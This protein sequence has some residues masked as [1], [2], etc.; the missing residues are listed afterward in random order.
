MS[1]SSGTNLWAKRL[2]AG[3][4]SSS[5]TCSARVRYLVRPCCG[6]TLGLAKGVGAEPEA[7]VGLPDRR[8]VLLLAASGWSKIEVGPLYAL[9]ATTGRSKSG[10]VTLPS[11]LRRQ[12]RAKVAASLG[13]VDEAA[14]GQNPAPAPHGVDFAC[15]IPDAGITI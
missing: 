10:I 7:E 9:L 15:R 5:S 6:A 14:Q 11:C 12:A 2:S 1:K 13:L 8:S 4:L 3:G